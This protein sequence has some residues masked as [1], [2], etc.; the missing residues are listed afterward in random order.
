LK[1]KLLCKKSILG[2]PSTNHDREKS[3]CWK[4]SIGE[5]LS[6]LYTPDFIGKTLAI[7][8]IFSLSPNRMKFGRN[9]LDNL[10]KPVL[11]QLKNMKLIIDDAFVCWL[12]ELKL[13]T[14]GQQSL[15]IKIWEWMA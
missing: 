12:L 7:E 9:D 8:L 1:G 4:V 6:S 15:E 13:P 3:N 11:D 5:E 14:H 2:E 10:A